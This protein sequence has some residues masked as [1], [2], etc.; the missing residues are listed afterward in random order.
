M[1][2]EK[3]R[4][5]NHLLL[6]YPEDASHVAAMEKIMQ[7]FD[8]AAILH[9]KDEWTKE[10]EAENAEHKAGTVKKAHWH[11]VLKFRN[12]RWSTALCDDLGIKHQYI[13]ECKNLDNALLYLLHYNN[14]DKV[15]YDDSEAFGP[16]TTRLNELVNKNE[17]TEGEKVV[18]LI[19]FI[20]ETDGPL[21]VTDF[22]TYCAL[23]GYWAEFRRSGAIFCKMIEEHNE[24][25]RRKDEN[26]R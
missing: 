4:S 14:N 11:V 6:L 1:A 12:H 20:E 17:K 19:R 26:D 22:A 15:P 21:R 7:S 5:R 23:N 9:D 24:R 2:L 25:F 18:E 13:E 8:Y 16:L 3:Y 10:D